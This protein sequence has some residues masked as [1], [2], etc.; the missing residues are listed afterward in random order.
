MPSVCFRG[1]FTFGM[2]GMACA[3][4]PLVR[5]LQKIFIAFA[6]FAGASA[7]ASPVRIVVEAGDWGSAAPTDIERVLYAAVRAFVEF[8]ADREA[9]AIRVIPGAS[10]PR[11]FHRK[12]ERG[13]YV[14]QLTARNRRWAQYAYQFAHEFCHVLSRFDNKDFEAEL[15]VAQ[16]QW[17]EEAVCELSSVLALRRMAKAWEASPPVPEWRD[18]AFALAEYAE[19]VFAKS[20]AQ[21]DLATWYSQHRLA[22]ARDPYQWQHNEVGAQLLLPLFEEGGTSWAAIGYLNAERQ[23]AKH[24]FADCLNAWRRAVPAEHRPFVERLIAAF[25][26]GASART[27]LR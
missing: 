27:A 6:M 14:V 2:G 26:L 13:E 9:V 17:F 15:L 18:Y 22:L 5:A 12:S 16:N 21:Y 23:S 8:P 19:G 1:I 10:H 25:G 7:D 11:V 3:M 20:P 4:E 24:S